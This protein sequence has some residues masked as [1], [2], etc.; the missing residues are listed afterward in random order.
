MYI[1]FNDM[2]T[3]SRIWI[4]QANR[5]LSE[6]EATDIGTFTKDFIQQWAAHSQPLKG[7]FQFLYNHFLI[8]SVDESFN[9]ASGCSI[10][11]S[12]HL[13]KQ[14]EKEFNVSFFDRTKV[15]FV[16]DEKVFLESINDLKKGIIE[17]KISDQSRTFNNLVKNKEELQNKWIVPAAESWLSRYFKTVKQH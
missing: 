10:D 16:K 3:Q 14:L 9:Q 11:A 12:V 8:I 2:P 7:S 17:G 13:V 1:P 4:Y 6:K 15:A 5:P